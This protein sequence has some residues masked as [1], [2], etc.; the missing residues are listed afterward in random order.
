MELSELEKQ[1]ADYEQSKRVVVYADK[2]TAERLGINIGDPYTILPPPTTK[3][4]AFERLE[5]IT[6][7]TYF[8]SCAR[9]FKRLY[10]INLR[11]LTDELKELN[12]F[13]EEAEKI[14]VKE[15]FE[16]AKMNLGNAEKFEYLRWKYDYYKNDKKEFTSFQNFYSSALITAYGKYFLYKNWIEEQIEL[17]KQNNKE[18]SIASSNNA[19]SSD[20][21]L[22]DLLNKTLAYYRD[23][24]SYQDPKIVFDNIDKPDSTDSAIMHIVIHKLQNDKYLLEAPIDLYGIG[25]YYYCISA[26]GILFINSGGYTTNTEIK[27]EPIKQIDIPKIENPYPQIFTDYNAYK[28]FDKLHNEFKDNS[29]HLA[30]YSFIYRMMYNDGFIFSNYKPE[31][32]KDWLS[33]EPYSIYLDLKLKT[34]NNCTTPNK[35][36]IYNTLK[37][38][39]PL[40]I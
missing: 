34:L 13:I 40:G 6:A 10:P 38:N 28:L 17:L 22:F 26:D 16:A 30:D 7:P 11:T 36:S 39:V 37:E 4:E 35:V 31:M 25:E 18:T 23:L 32:F 21:A 9:V 2:Q 27:I 19:L 8:L 24:G 15:A 1:I 20:S 29:K 12:K 33:K 5:N 14:S 3:E